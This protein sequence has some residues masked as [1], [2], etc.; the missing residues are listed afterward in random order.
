MNAKKL[1]NKNRHKKPLNIPLKTTVGEYDYIIY[2]ELSLILIYNIHDLFPGARRILQ[3]LWSR[4]EVRYGRSTAHWRCVEE[5]GWFGWTFRRGKVQWLEKLLDS[6]HAVVLLTRI[7]LHIN[8]C[9]SSVW[10]SYF[11]N[12]D[13]SHFAIKVIKHDSLC[14]VMNMLLGPSLLNKI[15]SATQMMLAVLYESLNIFLWLM[16][17]T[18]SW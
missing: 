1:I 2:K 8:K 5:S 3:Y 10:L 14:F 6:H 11:I 13:S 7:H 16:T 4:V 15:C 12:Q 18:E 9:D 17:H